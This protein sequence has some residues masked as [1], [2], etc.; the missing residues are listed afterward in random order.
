[1]RRLWTEEEVSFEGEHVTFSRSWLWPKPCQ[2]PHPPVLVGGAA[3]PKLFR[4]VA[5]FADGWMPIGGSGLATNLTELRRVTEAVG[6]DPGSIA[7]TVFGTSPDAAKIDYYESLGVER[8]VFTL[9][10]S[11]DPE[12]VLRALDRAATVIPGRP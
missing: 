12:K 6:R 10:S 8:V 1:M 3:G 5:E 2:Q 9:P 7:I 4:H 11:S